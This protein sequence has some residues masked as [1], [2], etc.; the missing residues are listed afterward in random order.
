MLDKKMEEY[1]HIFPNDKKG[2]DTYRLDSSAG[3][4]VEVSIKGLNMHPTIESQEHLGRTLIFLF[5]PQI[6]EAAKLLKMNKEDFE[7]GFYNQIIQ[8]KDCNAFAKDEPICMTNSLIS[9]LNCDVH[10][11][12]QNKNK[13]H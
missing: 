13:M 5:T 3:S 9:S 11:A 6:A 1:D 12:G 10:D 2:N 7:K 8:H 4:K